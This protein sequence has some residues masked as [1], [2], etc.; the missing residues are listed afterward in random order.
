MRE[1]YTTVAGTEKCY[2]KINNGQS[3]K[4]P[5]LCCF[6]GFF[7]RARRRSPSG[8]CVHNHLSR[9]VKTTESSL[10]RESINAAI[11]R[12]SA[13]CLAS[14]PEAAQTSSFLGLQRTALQPERLPTTAAIA[15]KVKVF[16]F[17][18]HVLGVGRNYPTVFL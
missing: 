12:E 6:G 5:S 15:K 9:S 10:S 14:C 11:A 17:P 2:K 4:P 8:D 7:L 13:R 3:K 18:P 1:F 16:T